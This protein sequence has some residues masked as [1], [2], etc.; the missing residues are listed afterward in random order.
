MSGA[1]CWRRRS[2]ALAALALLA[3]LAGAWAQS[4]PPSC[5][6]TRRHAPSCSYVDWRAVRSRLS[7]PFVTYANDSS[8]FSSALDGFDASSSLAVA[9]HTVAL[10][11]TI[12]FPAALNGT[13][14]VI[15]SADGAPVTFACAQAM[16]APAV[17]VDVGFQVVFVNITF[18]GC[19]ESAVVVADGASAGFRGCQFVSNRASGLGGALWVRGGVEAVDSNFVGNGASRGGAMAVTED[20]AAF[21]CTNC[22]FKGNAAADFGGTIYQVH[23]SFVGLNRGVVSGTGTVGG[24]GGGAFVGDASTLA[25]YGVAVADSL[26][27]SDGGF[28][29]VTFNSSLTAH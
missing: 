12:A 25:M 14:V 18:L 5:V 1:R 17:F 10:T 26:C 3:L 23:A 4:C 13:L 2:A 28:A 21:V 19:A 7:K 24:V 22:A 15:A 27:Y 29:S 16:G 11:D 6:C 9:P 20:D 8:S